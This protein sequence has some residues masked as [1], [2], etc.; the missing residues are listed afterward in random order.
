MDRDK[1]NVAWTFVRKGEEKKENIISRF[2]IKRMEITRRDIIRVRAI[3]YL[4]STVKYSIAGKFRWPFHPD[5]LSDE[6]FQDGNVCV[7]SVLIR[8]FATS[9][10]E[11]VENYLRV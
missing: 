5:S 7:C 8:K 11:D 1:M 4:R 2:N 6:I 10:N 3:L 9:G